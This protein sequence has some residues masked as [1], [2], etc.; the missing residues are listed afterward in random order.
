MTFSF[1]LQGAR[2][3]IEKGQIRTE[4]KTKFGL[5]IV[6]PSSQIFAIRSIFETIIKTVGYNFKFF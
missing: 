5:F 3:K 6:F 1:W 4:V 2:K